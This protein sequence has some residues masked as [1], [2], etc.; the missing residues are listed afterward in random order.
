MAKIYVIA[1]K[2]KSGKDLS[3]HFLKEHYEKQNQKIITYSCTMYLKNYIQKIY[4]WDGSEN[5]KPRDILQNLGKEIKNNYPD[6]F[7]HRMKEDIDFLRNKTDVIIITGVRLQTELSFLKNECGAILVKI[8]KHNF[9]NGLTQI[10]KKDITETDVDNYHSFD[11]V[12]ENDKE[13]LNLEKQIIDII[14][15]GQNEY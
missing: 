3:A 8:E 4:G 11:Y 9:D 12:V 7:L 5:T 14:E 1:G 2:A 10:Q 6:F 15:G 13:I